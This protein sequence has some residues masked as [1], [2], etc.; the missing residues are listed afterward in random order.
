MNIQASLEVLNAV[1]VLGVSAKKIAK[2][3]VNI[4][5]LP[6]AVELLKHVGEFVQAAKDAH[7][8]GEELKD[9]DQAELIQLGSKVYEIIKAI[10]APVV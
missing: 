10:S 6:E 1:E 3:G 7:L 9:V 4:S 2:D 5:D 8:V